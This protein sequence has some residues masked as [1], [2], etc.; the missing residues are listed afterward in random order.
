MKKY[1][2]TIL[3]V[4]LFFGVFVYHAHKAWG[5]LPAIFPDETSY[6]LGSRVQSFSQ[7]DIPNYLY[8]AIY[9]VT[10]LFGSDFLNAARVMNSFFFTLTALFICLIARMGCGKALSV[11]I[12]FVSV[13]MPFSLPVGFFMPEALYIM[14]VWVILWLAMRYRDSDP[15]RQGLL[16]GASIGVLM[17]IK[18]HA[19]FLVPG[20]IIYLILTISPDFSLASLKKSGAASV[21]AVVS[22]IGVKL[23]L[24]V[25][26][27]GT[28]GLSLLGSAYTDF[29][30]LGL[31]LVDL[32]NYVW[33][34]VYNLFGHLLGFCL[35]LGFPCVLVLTVI[36]TC[37]RAA[38]EGGETSLLYRMAVICL[39]FTLPL[40]AMSSGF[41]AMVNMIFPHLFPPGRFEIQARYYSF[42]FPAF[43]LV[44]GY[45]F[46]YLK[47]HTP[48][49][50]IWNRL[51]PLVPIGLSLYAIITMYTGY[52]LLYSPHYPDATIMFIRRQETYIPFVGLVCGLAVLPAVMWIYNIRKACFY[53]LFAF[54]PL[55]LVLGYHAESNYFKDK[56]TMIHP[57]IFY[58]QPLK[59]YLGDDA[60]DLI[61][62]DGSGKIGS[63]LLYF[64]DQPDIALYRSAK[65]G[66]VDM[67]KVKPN[68]KWALTI[69]QQWIPPA[70]VKYTVTI[71]AN[72]KDPKGNVL[73]V[74]LADFDHSVDLT[75]DKLS[76]PVAKV[77]KGEGTV[78][79]KFAKTLPTNYYLRLETAAEA[80]AA[81]KE[82]GLSIENLNQQIVAKG[83]HGDRINQF[84]LLDMAPAQSI[85]IW[86]LE[87]RGERSGKVSDIRKISIIPIDHPLRPPTAAMQPPPPPVNSLRPDPALR[88]LR[89]ESTADAS[90]GE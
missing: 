10:K 35:L 46:T 78:S 64:L 70:Y 42:L 87:N 88:S 54:L 37:R 3:V 17:L 76:W 58:G 24:G 75:Q 22:A 56:L 85:H 67:D 86:E 40:V 16:L 20:L 5:R 31:G 43:V 51:S 80:V 27:A 84:R 90:N 79:V 57:M 71:A 2:K 13:M 23:L 1:W 63:I 49:R 73:L 59:D 7:A 61:V 66:P 6:S 74:R 68:H 34:T 82:Y 15:V 53:Y 28:K 30:I 33:Y 39:A 55:Y 12:A 9:S 81:E 89:P 14:G 19:L 18:V 69:G 72:P 4:L 32:Y 11:F 48:Q 8:Y 36:F 50:S 83:T 52:A 41:S 65:T 21:C 77:E 47:D 38:K 62:F 26:F 25:L 60:R 45:A 44:A 29:T